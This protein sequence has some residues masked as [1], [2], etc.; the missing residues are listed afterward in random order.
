MPD[1]PPDVLGRLYHQLCVA[2]WRQ[3]KLAE[4]AEVELKRA[5]ACFAEDG[6]AMNRAITHDLLALLS[7]EREDL[8]ALARHAAQA[9]AAIE[10]M[11]PRDTV[12]R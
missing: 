11:S 2:C 5:L 7:V 4:A 9:R 12:A 1:L 8:A 3:S 10:A 6:T